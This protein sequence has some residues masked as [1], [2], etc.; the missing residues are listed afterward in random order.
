MA[1]PSITW[2]SMCSMSLTSVVNPR[3][4]LLTM[5]SVISCAESPSY[6]QTTL[7]TGMFISGRIS[8]GVRVIAMGLRIR[9]NSAITI[10]VYGRRSARATIHIGFGPFYLRNAYHGDIE[11]LSKT[12]L[13]ADPEPCCLWFSA[14]DSGY[15]RKWLTR[16]RQ[17]TI[18]LWII[19]SRVLRR[20]L[21]CAQMDLTVLNVERQGLLDIRPRGVLIQVLIKLADAIAAD[22]RLSSSKDLSY[23]VRTLAAE[24]AA[25]ISPHF[26]QI[27]GRL[28][29]ADVSLNPA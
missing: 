15:C 2:V 16:Q 10:N 28:A 1:R 26:V 7:M 14:E 29:F 8:T 12:R 5:R 13:Q 25:L 19:A 20:G 11:T 24:A 6:C 4:V 27:F 3:S 23:L 22:V 9:I 17:A 18:Q 21:R